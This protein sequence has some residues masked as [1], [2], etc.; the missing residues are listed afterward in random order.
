[1]QNNLKKRLKNGDVLHGMFMMIPSPA[2]VE[3]AG[4]AGFDYVILD[5][6][7]GASGTEMLE[8]QVRAAEASN[9]P[10][11]VRTVSPMAGEILR[12]LE[13]GATG[14]LVPHVTTAEQA[15]AIARAAHYPPFGIRGMATTSRVGR[16]GITTVPGHLQEAQE[17]T[18]VVVQIED[19]EALPN[20]K[21]IA[22][23]EGIDAV[24]IGPADLAISL[25]FP[26]QPNHPKVAEAI[27]QIIKDVK[28][29]G[30]VLAGFAKAEADAAVLVEQGIT[31]VCLSST[32][33]IS[34]RFVE[35]AKNLRK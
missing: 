8:H 3:M 11:I 21:A 4:Y 17:T 14:I 7:H 5:T 23:T 16:H 6:E 26:G 18:V 9:I 1:M 19:A 22:Q 30:Q 32:L 10:S 31:L 12:A 15:A 28:S 35:L 25:G 27:A 24:F 29:A 34:S 20:V 13:T 2:V 33:I